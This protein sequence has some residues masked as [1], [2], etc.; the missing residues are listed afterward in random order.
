MANIL[1][2]TEIG[3]DATDCQRG[4]EAGVLEL[5]QPGAAQA[6]TDC[7]AEIPRI[8]ARR[9]HRDRARAG[10]SGPSWRISRPPVRSRS[11]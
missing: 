11:S 2:I 10:R 3:R 5:W 1:G 6:A 4:Y 7:A 8:S 9:P